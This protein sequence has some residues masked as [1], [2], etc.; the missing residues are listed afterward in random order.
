MLAKPCLFCLHSFKPMIVSPEIVESAKNN[1]RRLN[2]YV[3]SLGRRI[4]TDEVVD[5]LAERT[6]P[7]AQRG[8][9]ALLRIMRDRRWHVSAAVHTNE[10]DSTPHL[11]VAVR[12]VGYHLRLD[13]RGCIFDITMMDGDGVERPSGN[14]PWVRPGSI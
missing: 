9:R 6:S 8:A 1:G 14:R 11:T 12:G 3:P 4:T 13:G 7:A 5:L 10:D 2:Q